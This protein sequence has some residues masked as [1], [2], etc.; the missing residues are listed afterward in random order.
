VV[1]LAERLKRLEAELEACAT[2]VKEVTQPDLAAAKPKKASMKAN[3]GG[4]LSKVISKPAKIVAKHAQ[5][6]TKSEE[7]SLTDN[8]KS[9]LLEALTAVR[10][11]GKLRTV[12]NVVLEMDRLQGG[13]SLKYRK[14][15]GYGSAKAMFDRA[16]KEKL[17]RYGP[18][19]AT[20]MPTIYFH[21]ETVPKKAP[22][23]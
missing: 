13:E 18:V 3:D 8:E 5:I 2:P 4:T 20:D 16:K 14:Y 23:P 6:T 15:N 10:L 17:I 22:V 9:C 21:N 19:D 7:R 1:S 12:S 11:A